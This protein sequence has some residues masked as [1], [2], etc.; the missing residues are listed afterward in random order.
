MSVS[1]TIGKIDTI[2]SYVGGLFSL[3][4]TGIAFFLGSYSEYKYELYVAESMLTV[5]D[6]GKRIRESDLGF[7]TYI[8]YKVYDWLDTFGIAPKCLTKL[9]DMH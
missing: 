9:S 4:F 3:L 5:D 7:V 8:L 6:K 1:R 2:L